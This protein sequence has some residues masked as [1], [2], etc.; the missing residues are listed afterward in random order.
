MDKDILAYQ[1]WANSNRAGGQSYAGGYAKSAQG[2]PTRTGIGSLVGGTIGGIGGG[3]L[4][5]LAL[6]GVGT[7]AGGVAGGAAGSALGE[8]LD[9][10]LTGGRVTSGKQVAGEALLGA[11]PSVLGAGM[12]I[13]KGARAGMSL[14]EALSSQAAKKAAEGGAESISRYSLRGKLDAKANDVLA[15]QYGTI[16]KPVARQTR[17]P[18]TIGTLAQRGIT[19]PQDAE[20]IAREFT[21]GN[22]LVS[23]AVTQAIGNKAKVQVGDLTKLASESAV[24]N[25]LSDPQVKTL[26]RYVVAV[27]GKLK[28][29]S[30]ADA[31]DAVRRLEGKVADL[32][33]KGGN[34]H[35]PTGDDL[36]LSKVLGGL[37]ETLK[38][39]IY[40]QAN[41]K[42][43]LTPKLRDSLL[44]LHPGNKKWAS[45]VEKDVMGAKDVSQLRNAQSAFVRVGK[46]IDEGDVN[47]VTA[48]GRVGNSLAGGPLGQALNALAGTQAAKRVTAATLRGAGDVAG[49]GAVRA[50]GQGGL[51]L[52]GQSGVRAFVNPSGIMARGN[53]GEQM[54][55]DNGMATGL[56]NSQAGM[57]MDTQ[58]GTDMASDPT[59]NDPFSAENMKAMAIQDIMRTGGKNL[60]KIA[61]LQALF[62]ASS[63][64]VKLTEAQSARQ[65]ALGLTNDALA[66]LQAGGVRTGMLNGPVEGIKAKFGMAD[67]KTLEFNTTA[68]AIRAAIAKARAGTAMSPGEEKMLNQ[69]TPKVGDSMQQMQ[70]KLMG[71][72]RFL[73]QSSQRDMQMGGGVAEPT[74]QYQ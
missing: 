28:T 70:V 17:L 6:P 39:R 41:V 38:D 8:A 61:Q 67:Q 26:N 62:G 23:N 12:K 7:A 72:K 64:P 53:A 4:G 1:A 24:Q 66:M 15:S 57:P 19:K 22:G 13:A 27:S 2:K 60:A 50:T 10:I 59:T 3:I 43:V 45:F 21:G 20:R 48:G 46:A 37:A 69:Y 63:K 9:Q 16:S 51:G 42:S 36:A 33:G 32:T 40:S 31:M 54:A 11:A 58:M 65:E 44:S 18:E 14:T 74:A 56:D 25:M 29:G 49:S 35:L 47:A 68:S 52:I 30:A 34:Y 55:G 71:L 5:T 73:T